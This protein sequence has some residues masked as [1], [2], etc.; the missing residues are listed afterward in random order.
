MSL[1]PGGRGGSSSYGMSWGSP[2]SANRQLKVGV[3]VSQKDESR[4]L[5]YSILASIPLNTNGTVSC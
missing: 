4:L 2:S 1:F 3:V 5:V